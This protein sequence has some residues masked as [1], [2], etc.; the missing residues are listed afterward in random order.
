MNYYEQ[1]KWVDEYIGY[2]A[3]FIYVREADKLLIKIPNEAYKLNPQG[4]KILKH[5]LSGESI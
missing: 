5:L 3:P 4:L 1:I 2:V